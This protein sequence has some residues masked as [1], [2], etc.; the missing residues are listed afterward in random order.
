MWFAGGLAA[1][2]SLIYPSVSAF[3]SLYAKDNQQGKHCLD[4]FMI[5]ERSSV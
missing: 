3:V 1:L 4:I 2:S 5:N